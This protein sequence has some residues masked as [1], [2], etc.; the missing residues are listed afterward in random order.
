MAGVIKHARSR[1]GVRPSQSLSPLGDGVL[2]FLLTDIEGSVA[3]WEHAPREMRAAVELHD[4]VLRAEI[5]GRRGHIFR[6]AGDSFHA[7]FAVPS[8]ALAAAAAIVRALAAEDFGATGGLKVRMAIHAGPV[9]S[10]DGDY[11]GQGIN[12]AARLLAVAQGDQVLVTHVVAAM[13]GAELPAGASLID[14]G[15]HLL[16]DGLEPERLH[17]L[18]LAGFRTSPWVSPD[19]SSRS[20]VPL[21]WNS[22]IGRERELAEIDAAL[23]GGRLLTIL[24]SGGAGKTRLAIEAGRLLGSKYADGVRFIDLSTV[25]DPALA[26]EKIASGVEFYGSPD[27]SAAGSLLA[28]L[29][30]KAS[31][32]ILDNCEHL[33][34]ALARVTQKILENCKSV[35]VLATSRQPLGIYGEHLLRLANLE[36]PEDVDSQG[37]AL[38]SPAVRLFAERARAQGSFELT[39]GN[40]GAVAELCR[41][42]DGLP[43][44][45]ELAVPRLRAGRLDELAKSLGEPL[46]LQSSARSIQARHFSLGNVF[47]W[48][49]RLLDGAEKV[50]LQ[51][52]SVFASGCTTEQAVFV[53]EGPDVDADA[54]PSLL[55]VL[56]DKS[57]LVV[58]ATGPQTRFRMLETTKAF[59]HRKLREENQETATRLRFV[60]QMVATMAEATKRWPRLGTRSWMEIY[61]VEVDNVRSCLEW[62]L[63]EEHAVADGVELVSF[64]LRLWDELGLLAERQNWFATALRRAAPAASEVK[65]R[66]Y[67]GS[68]SLNAA[69]DPSGYGMAKNAIELLRQQPAALDLGDALARAGASLMTPANTAEAEPYLLEAYSVLRHLGPTKQL[70]SCL[71]SLC[72][73]EFFRGDLHAALRYSFEVDSVS[74]RLDDIRGVISNQINRADLRFAMGDYAAAVDQAQRV[75]DDENASTRQVTIARANLASYLLGNEEVAAARPIVMRALVDARAL[76]WKSVFNRSL[77]YAAYIAVS[78]RTP[79]VAAALVGYVQNVEPHWDTTRQP[80]ER[81]LHDRLVDELNRSLPSI[82]LSSFRQTGAQW[83]EADAFAAARYVLSRTR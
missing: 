73:L 55:V 51:R 26:V 21:T 24:G 61:A 32:L 41:R 60:R 56:A 38:A 57:L 20:N 52:L 3:K 16:R 67:L 69:A 27:Q 81:A 7:A 5:I 82:G 62:A 46:A 22:F 66:L 64:S 29:R 43:L 70:S 78:D 28:T 45:I 34:E 4:D 33:L 11:F 58:D 77:G 37:A 25:D 36:C 44:A 12:R 68:T 42:L 35:S 14:L 72:A 23:C 79:E 63:G 8:D 1:G 59:S 9:Q 18:V 6:T 19:L 47:D 17:Q 49:Y 10:R 71:R 30:E 48:S 74:G 31:L 75:V 76:S 13:G 39:E 15:T 2:T 80:V 40:A 83:E 53:C 50:L 65:A 54:I